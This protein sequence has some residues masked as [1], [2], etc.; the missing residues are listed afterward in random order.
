MQNLTKYKKKIHFTH[1][2]QKITH[3]SW[4][5]IMYKYTN[6]IVTVH[7]YTYVRLL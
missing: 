3:I 7:K 2:E 5:K 4:C 6:I 1:F